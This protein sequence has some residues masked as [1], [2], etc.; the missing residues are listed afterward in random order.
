MSAMGE[1][2]GE[3]PERPDTKEFWAL[4]AMILQYDGRMEETSDEERDAAFEAMVREHVGL[5]E[6]AYMAMQRAMR[7]TGVVNRMELAATF[8]EVMKLSATWMEAF[9]LGCEWEKRRQERSV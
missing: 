2:F 1:V 9:V 3:R 8:Q 5:E 4:S 6:V 7:A